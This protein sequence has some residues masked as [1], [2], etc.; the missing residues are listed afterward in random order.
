MYNH[1]DLMSKFMQ[2]GKCEQAMS[3]VLTCWLA[4]RASPEVPK[5]WLAADYKQRVETV[6]SEEGWLQAREHL[7]AAMTGHLCDKEY[8]RGKW[9]EPS[10]FMTP[11]GLNILVGHGGHSTLARLLGFYDLSEVKTYLDSGN[12]LGGVD[13]MENAGW[14]HVSDKKVYRCFPAVTRHMQS[15]VDSHEGFQFVE[16]RSQKQFAEVPEDWPDYLKD[17]TN[18]RFK[19]HGLRTN[20]ETVNTTQGAY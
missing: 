19:R 2:D 6:L 4:H 15:L 5:R 10:S 7:E 13:M 11:K 9:D 18:A 3:V 17:I 1:A 20:D 8:C 14:V 16:V 12:I